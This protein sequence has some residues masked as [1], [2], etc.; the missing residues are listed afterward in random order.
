LKEDARADL[1]SH[2]SELRA[3]LVRALVYAAVGTGVVWI[4]FDPVYRF[5]MHPIRAALGN[6]GG[7]L[8]VRGILEGFLVRIEIAF[9]GG[10]ILAAPLIFYEIWAFVSPGLTRGERGA[11]RPLVPASG[12]LFLMGVAVGYVMTG[13]AVRVLL[14][15]IPPDTEALLTLNETILLVLKFYLAFGFGFQV[16]II[17]VLLAKIGIV[18][19]GMLLRRWREA[20]IIIF[21]MAGIITPT[22]DPITMTVC[23]LPMVVLY[24]GTIAAI[25]LMER[26]SRRAKARGEG[27]AG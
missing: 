2:L 12:I 16:P 4:L 13:P 26:K 1:V 21:M 24:A 8:T 3:R 15:Y 11:V 14:R 23:A 6:V 25:K 10:V 27:P 22:W 20:V 7:Q 18:D 17:L 19:S 9:I 5:L